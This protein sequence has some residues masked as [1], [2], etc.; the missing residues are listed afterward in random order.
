MSTPVPGHPESHDHDDHAGARG[1]MA[2]PE[3][4]PQEVY[5]RYW[6]DHVY[7]AD[8][9]AQLTAR[10]LITGCVIGGIMSFSNLYVGLK[11]GWGLGASITAAI[12]A[13]GVFSG[14]RGVVKTGPMAAPFTVL[15]NNTMQTAA[16]SAAYMTSAGL[17]S[18]IPAL[19]LTTGHSLSFGQLV[20]WLIGISLLGAVAAIPVKKKLINQERLRFPSGIAC[21]ETLRTLHGSGTEG[22]Q[23]AKALAGGSAVGALVAFFREGLH[24]LPEAIPAFGATLMKK[25]IALE[26]SLVMVGAGALMGLRVTLSMVVMGVVA[27]GVMPGWLFDQGFITCGPLPEDQVCGIQHIGYGQIVGWT[28]WPGVA[29]MVAHSLV[30]LA[31]QSPRMVRGLVATLQQGRRV[32]TAED[33]RLASIEIPTSWFWIGMAIMA[34]VSIALQWTWFGIHPV[35]GFIAVVL[36]VLLSFVAARSTGETDITPVGGMGKVTQ[37]V[38][39]GLIRGQI[40]PNLM[41]AA[42]T[43]GVASQVGD[44][45]TDLKTGH[46]LGSKPRLQFVAQIAGVFVGAVFAAWAYTLLVD[47]ADLG[48]ERWPA[49]S[50]LTWAKVAELLSNGVE[51]L[52]HHKRT[53]MLLGAGAGTLLAVIEAFAPVAVRRFLPSAAGMGIALMIPFFNSLSMLLG[54]VIA[55]VLHRLRPVLAER[56]TIVVASGLIAGETLMA[57]AVLAFNVFAGGV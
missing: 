38:F 6:L 3:D 19:Y 27:W 55:M 32:P 17:V 45:L 13:F 50:A 36:A 39:G 35:Y 21:A 52:E 7:Q 56:Y 24:L 42:V 26:G 44:L 37:L 15:E 47:P 57:V 22:V 49:P 31:L 20:P 43:G 11:T 54:A 51:S 4:T 8:T 2:L 18:A 41:T 1:L 16:S 5:D 46:L 29:I 33:R 9:Q 23:Q 28:L 53:A 34:P 30:G 40:A 12:V 10:A 48:T 14:L 25:T